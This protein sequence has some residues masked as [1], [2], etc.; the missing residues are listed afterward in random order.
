MLSNGPSSDETAVDDRL[1]GRVVAGKYRIESFLGGGGM[2][3]VYRARQLA[4]D[5]V[6]AIKV[7]RPALVENGGGSF[8]ARFKR[9]AKAAS[10]FNHP[11][12]VGVLDF[13]E[14][15]DG[16][17][18]MAMEY[19][20][21]RHLQEILSE[22]A[23]FPDQV[24]V[25]ILSQTLSALSKAH[26]MNI[27]HRDVKPENIVILDARDDEGRQIVKVCDF[28]IAKLG[29][30][31]ASP[32]GVSAPRT[33][34][35]LTNVGLVLGTPEYMSPEQGQGNEIDAR[36]DIYSVGVILYQMLTGQL[37]FHADTPVGIIYKH[38]V[39]PV[40]LPSSILPN[41]NPRL[42]NVVMRALA[43]NRDQRY[44]NAREMRADLRAALGDGSL[45]PISDP[46]MS[47][48]PATRP[49]G[50]QRSI[51]LALAETETSLTARKVSPSGGARSKMYW[52]AGVAGAALVIGVAAFTLRLKASAPT[53]TSTAPTVS[54][55]PSSVPAVSVAIASSADKAAPSGPSPSAS[56]VHLDS[57]TA[58]SGAR[59]AVGRT[60]APGP[61]VRPTAPTTAT[62]QA[63]P[64]PPP[65]V[66]PPAPAP[67]DSVKVKGF[68]TRDPWAK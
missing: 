18:Y 12:S 24:I 8:P 56:V 15:P 44:A 5:K 63:A 10:A 9:E 39:E 67:T 21:G 35:A 16:L 52:L 13:G 22:S 65:P 33:H 20:E 42:E 40:V 60:P 57:T 64:P 31:D 38:T 25:D 3:T 6:V 32:S 4:L 17:L 55:L 11:N 1:V 68:D 53:T 47:S 7:M 61:R 41:V 34:G 2:G 30:R 62:T 66:P 19:L 45:G 46:V 28:G 26:E 23:P 54:A 50:P 37:P 59:S 48:L 29:T 14:E 36:A 51:V 58:P 43:K 49:S 27:I